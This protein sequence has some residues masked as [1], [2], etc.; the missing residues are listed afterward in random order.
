MLSFVFLSQPLPTSS[1]SSFLSLVTDSSPSSLDYPPISLLLHSL[2]S[3]LRFSR[4][5]TVVVFLFLL[6]AC[7][8]LWLLGFNLLIPPASL[9]SFF[10]TTLGVSSVRTK[11]AVSELKR[12]SFHLLGLLIPVIYYMG[13][14][15]TPLHLNKHTAVLIMC[16]CTAAVWLVEAMRLWWPTF[17]RAYSRLFA[18]LLRKKEV[19]EDNVMLTGVGYFFLGNLLC[20]FL[21]EPT[22]AVCASRQHNTQHTPH[23]QLLWLFRRLS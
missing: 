19:S 14:K 13:S 16:A 23:T 2:H 6:V 15:Y 10:R 11:R 1:A 22:I 20:V 9:T 12:K 17:R 3:L 8:A 7:T 4:D 21:F 18:P 5:N